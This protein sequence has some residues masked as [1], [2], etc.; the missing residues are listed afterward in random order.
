MNQELSGSDQDFGP[1]NI[2]L[3]VTSLLAIVPAQFL[4][5]K[6]EH[7][8]AEEVIKGGVELSFAAKEEQASG[9]GY[10]LSAPGVCCSVSV[11]AESCGAIPSANF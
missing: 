5:V 7:V 8:V 9:T 10:K 2:K 4:D 6:D 1:T 11:P 3:L